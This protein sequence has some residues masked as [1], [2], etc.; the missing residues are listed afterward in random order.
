MNMRNIAQNHYT[1]R[2]FFVTCNLSSTF[3]IES[4]FCIGPLGVKSPE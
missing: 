1:Q 4:A 2:P 3:R